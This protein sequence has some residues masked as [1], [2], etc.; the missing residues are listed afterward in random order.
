QGLERARGDH[1]LVLNPDCEIGPG[2]LERLI[3][4]LEAGPDLAAAAPKLIDGAGVVAR[5]CGRFPDLWTLLCDHLGM[6]Q[7]R[8]ESRWFGS[9]KYGGWAMESLDRVDWASGAARLIPRPAFERVG[10]LDESIL[11]YMA[12]VDWC[13]RAA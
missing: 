10:G 4:T 5:S 7:A 9:H 13:R 11:M 3:R 1:L 2:A 6:A 8:P 12:E